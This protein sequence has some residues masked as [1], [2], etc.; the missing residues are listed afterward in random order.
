M[1]DTGLP[2]HRGD[3]R[4]RLRDRPR[5]RAPRRAGRDRR[6]GRGKAQACAARSARPCPA[7]RSTRTSRTCPPRPRSG[8]SPATLRAAYPRLDVLVNNAGAIF[9]R[10]TLTVDGI[11]RTWALDHLGYVLLPSNCSTP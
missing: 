5:A 7:R 6:A 3:L 11:E 9:D 1:R 10:R 2:R 8:A 4:H